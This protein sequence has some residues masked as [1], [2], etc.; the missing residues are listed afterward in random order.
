MKKKLLY[1]AESSKSNFYV[2]CS[3]TT[4]LITSVSLLWRPWYSALDGRGIGFMV[5]KRS[6][7]S[8][9]CSLFWVPKCQLQIVFTFTAQLKIR[10]AILGCDHAAIDIGWTLWLN[11]H[12]PRSRRWSQLCGLFTPGS[13]RAKRRTRVTRGQGSFR[14]KH[15]GTTGTNIDASKCY[16]IFLQSVYFHFLK[17]AIFPFCRGLQEKLGNLDLR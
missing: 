7:P 5:S 2:H 15:N 16:I 11:W 8:P 10:V 12:D 1:F 17:N 4:A 13:T 14:R 3:V 6:P 9:I